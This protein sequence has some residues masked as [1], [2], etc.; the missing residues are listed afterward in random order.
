MNREMCHDC[1]YIRIWGINGR[2]CFPLDNDGISL[3]ADGTLSTYAGQLINPQ[4]R[5]RAYAPHLLNPDLWLCVLHLNSQFDK[6]AAETVLIA[7]CRN[8]YRNNCRNVS[9]HANN[10][11]VQF[12]QQLP[13]PNGLAAI[14]MCGRRPNSSRI[15]FVGTASPLWYAKLHPPGNNMELVDVPAGVTKSR[16]MKLLNEIVAQEIKMV[17]HFWRLNSARGLTESKDMSRS[18]FVQ[19][20]CELLANIKSDNILLMLGDRKSLLSPLFGRMSNYLENAAGEATIT[21]DPSA[22]IIV[23]S[24]DPGFVFRHQHSLIQQQML[25]QLIS[26]CIMAAHYLNDNEA[27]TRSQMVEKLEL[28]HNSSLYQDVKNCRAEF[29]KTIKKSVSRQI[30]PRSAFTQRIFIQAT[31]EPLSSERL[32]QF[33]ELIELAANPGVDQS[34]LARLHNYSV[35]QWKDWFLGLPSGSNATAIAKSTGRSSMSDELRKVVHLRLRTRNGVLQLAASPES[36]LNSMYQRMSSSDL[37]RWLPQ[38]KWSKNKRRKILLCVQCERIFVADQLLVPNLSSLSH[39][40]K[41]QSNLTKLDECFFTHDIAQLLKAEDCEEVMNQLKEL[42]A[43]IHRCEHRWTALPPNTLGHIFTLARA[44]MNIMNQSS[45]WD[46]NVSTSIKQFVERIAQQGDA[47]WWQRVGR[48]ISGLIKALDNGVFQL[49]PLYCDKC[50]F[51]ALGPAI[52]FQ[53]QS[54]INRVGP[55]GRPTHSCHGKTTQMEIDNQV[56]ISSIKD[57]PLAFARA[58]VRQACVESSQ[59]SDQAV[60]WL[61]NVSI[62]DDDIMNECD[63]TELAVMS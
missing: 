54:R 60:Q 56:S 20:D 43:S 62:A 57:L 5:E 19:A 44:D 27:M 22:H 3:L 8:L 45:H 32:T 34:R 63:D 42:G 37:T 13:F 55:M 31:G 58:V 36:M 41:I 1:V 11:Y 61:S 39:C 7:W 40:C 49:H 53:W 6:D 29:V 51:L 17:D 21:Q 50:E 12:D 47:I 30:V 18:D 9:A 10:H 33:Q 24:I 59:T 38:N 26:L 28:Y 25:V 35:E 23:A 16:S 14:N 4:A 52:N 46:D 2:N 15:A 48:F